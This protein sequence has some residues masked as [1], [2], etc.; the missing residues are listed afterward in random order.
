MEYQIK[1]FTQ[2]HKYIQDVFPSKRKSEHN[3]EKNE[4]I[5]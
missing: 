1:T 3:K 4:N 2:L 5:F